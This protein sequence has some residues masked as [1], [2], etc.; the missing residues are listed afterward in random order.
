MPRLRYNVSGGTNTLSECLI[1]FREL[2][3]LNVNKKI[4]IIQSYES[5]FASITKTNHAFSFGA[6]RMALY[7]ILEALQIKKDDEIIVP[8]F[9]CVVVPNAILYHGAKPIYVDIE[10]KMFNIDINKIESHITSKTKALYAQHTFGIPCDIKKIS[11]IANRHGLFVIE[12]CAHTLGSLVD[13]EPVGSLSDVAFFSMD[14]TKLISTHLGGMAVTNDLKI[15]KKLSFIQGKSQFLSS[16]TT[17]KILITFIFEFFFLS[18]L[19]LWFGKVIQ[20]VMIKTKIL[21]YFNDELKIKKPNNYP[22]P[23]R[24]SSALAKIGINQL[25]MLK[26]NI[27]Y[28]KKV[29]NY[30]EQKIGWNKNNLNFIN[31]SVLLR[32]SFLVSNRCKFENHFKYHFDLGIWYTSVVHGRNMDLSYVG[33][34]LGKCPVAE[35]VAK[36]IVNFPTHP[37]IPISILKKELNKNWDWLKKNIILDFKV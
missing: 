14:R 12:D 13:D 6:G 29:A 24:L 37:G 17:K 35:K 10:P 25:N 22:F 9:T 19:L 32:Y 15:A 8:A 11:E 28:R 5:S 34:K 30:L 20:N 31:N 4:N 3:S 33:Y 18:P 2:F 36:H 21:F 1:A 27:K 26:K 7:A 23:C 16:F